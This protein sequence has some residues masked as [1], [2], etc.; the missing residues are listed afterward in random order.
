MNRAGPPLLFLL[1]ASSALGGCAA[2]G[3]FPSLARRAAES[4]RSVEEPVRV[5]LQV[6]EEEA[7]RARVA[8]LRAR[9]AAGDR[10]FDATYGAAEAAARAAGGRGSESWI[11]AQQAL[12]RLEA[13][14]EAT[15][16]ALGELDALAVSRAGTPT[17]AGDF[18]SIN[19]AVAA[20]ERMAMAQQQRYDSLRDRLS[21]R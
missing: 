17:N 9:A 8:E 21:G 18:A 6:A 13:A 16:Q 11:V 4:D 3:D 5:P 7:L 19:E 15:M 14:R 10:E 12:S 1:G 2:Q 20:V